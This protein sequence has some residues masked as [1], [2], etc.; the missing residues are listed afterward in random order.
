MFYESI[1]RMQS[2]QKQSS[3]DDKSAIVRQFTPSWNQ[4]IVGK[5]IS[6]YWPLD[7]AWYKGVVSSINE[8][9]IKSVY[10]RYKDGDKEWLDLKK[11][12]FH[13][14]EI[15]SDDDD[16]DSST[17]NG[18]EDDGEFKIGD[19]KYNDSD[20]DDDDEEDEDI[21]LFAEYND[22]DDDDDDDEDED[23]DLF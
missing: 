21:D 23:I 16:S 14:Y 11:E 18:H 7:D 9:K 12:N 10:V 22:S 1:K 6:I 13:F 20:D 5:K 3:N 2:L 4:S 17:N 8:S 19:T 15:S